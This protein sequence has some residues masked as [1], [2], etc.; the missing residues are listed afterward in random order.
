MRRR[1]DRKAIIPGGAGILFLSCW[2]SGCALLGYVPSLLQS[3]FDEKRTELKQQVDQGLVSKEAAEGACV[4]M[5]RGVDRHH[6]APPPYS[7]EVCHFGSFMDKR[8]ELTKALNQGAISPKTWEHTCRD[9]PDQPKTGTPCELNQLQD[10]LKAWRSQIERGYT[11]KEAVTLDC[12]TV[13]IAEYGE[14]RA[15]EICQL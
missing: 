7:D 9:L 8:Y 3:D 4:L 11:S 1:S 12:L 15:K 2:L 14:K 13:A 5:L 6:T 10:K